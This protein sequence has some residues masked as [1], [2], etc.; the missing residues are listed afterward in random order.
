MNKSVSRR[1]IRL[2]SIPMIL[3][4]EACSM[5]PEET[6]EQTLQHEEKG[7][8]QEIQAVTPHIEYKIPH[9]NIRHEKLENGMNILMMKD[10]TVPQVLMQI[11][12]AVGSADEA[13]SSSDPE[14]EGSSSSQGDG[15]SGERGYAHLL[16]HM[17]FKGTE[18]MKEGDIDSI[19]RKY[20]ASFN[21]FTSQDMTSY[22]FEV[23]KNNWKVFLDVIADCMKNVQFNQEHLSSELHA[24]IQEL[25]MYKDSHVRRIIAEIMNLSFPAHHPYHHPIIGYKEDLTSVSADKLRTFYEKYYHPE[26]ATLLVMGD[27]NFDEVM[28]EVKERFGD[29]FHAAMTPMSSRC[30]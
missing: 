8:E 9:E 6:T 19:A 4:C 1:M 14:K 22:Y 25:K 10:S 5:K 11:G 20:G 24:V 12:Y 3:I 29:I 27:I 16:E 18:R 28:K 21:A 13:A 23:D 30:M 26:R 17:V 15:D 2:L 7:K